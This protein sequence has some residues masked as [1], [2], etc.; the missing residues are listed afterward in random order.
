MISLYYFNNNNYYYYYFF[1]MTFIIIIVVVMKK[2]FSIKYIGVIMRLVCSYLSFYQVRMT[3]D[4]GMNRPKVHWPPI[5]M[6]IT[7][8]LEE[9]KDVNEICEYYNNFVSLK[10]KVSIAY[11][12]VSLDASKNAVR[13]MECNAGNLAT[14]IMRTHFKTDVGKK[15]TSK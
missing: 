8:D 13:T 5:R 2:T 15:H 3:I 12:D 9:D 14:D 10:T 4:D 7:M 6:G 1:I 11:S